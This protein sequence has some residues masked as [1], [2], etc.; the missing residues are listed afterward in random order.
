M[1]SSIIHSFLKIYHYQD[2]SGSIKNLSSVFNFIP[3]FW[4]YSSFKYYLNSAKKRKLFIKVA[5]AGTFPL[6][7]TGFGQYFFKWYGP[8]EIFNGLI[9]WFQ[10]PIN[11]SDGL[12]GLF[13]NQNYAGSWLSFIWPFCIALFLEKKETLFQRKINVIFLLSIGLASFLTNSRN[14][15]AGLF[16]TPLIV[17]GKK[18]LVLFLTIFLTFLVIFIFLI[19]PILSGFLKDSL[20][21][22]IPLGFIENINQ[23]SNLSDFKYIVGS[24]LHML[25]NSF[26]YLSFNPFIGIGSDSFSDIYLS[27]YGIYRGHTHN[28]ILE[29][30]LSFGLPATFI[31]VFSIALL[32]I[33]SGKRIFSFNRGSIK[34]YNFY[35]KAIWSSILFFLFS[36]MF[37]IQYYDGRISIFAWTL[38][39]CLGQIIDE[40]Y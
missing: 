18:R 2:L 39:S 24:R 12:S 14:A 27:E 10:K 37:D 6:L 5:I 15:L 25:I 26:K 13:S 1:I 34:I 16:I 29:V 20:L 7:I 33:N 21:K 9:I 3:Y 11:N 8:F 32:I 4:I 35:E 31:L 30:A 17:I 38:L 40:K 19:S 22:L 36:Q 28:I 23:I